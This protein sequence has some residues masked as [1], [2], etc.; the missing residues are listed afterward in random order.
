MVRE[1]KLFIRESAMQ[2]LQ[3][4]NISDLGDD[5]FCYSGD[6]SSQ[7]KEFL[8]RSR[9]RGLL[10]VR[11]IREISKSYLSH[12][13]SLPA[14]TVLFPLVYHSTKTRHED[15]AGVCIPDNYLL[16]TI[17]LQAATVC[18]KPDWWTPLAFSINRTE[19]KQ[20]Q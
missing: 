12:Y 9:S 2:K 7:D 10:I 1:R 11:D 13:A 14:L 18:S 17:P 5:V 20:Y 8:A 6:L 4:R 19:S 16:K 3:R 15:Y